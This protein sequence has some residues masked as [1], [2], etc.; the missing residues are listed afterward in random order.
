MDSGSDGTD[1]NQEGE[2]YDS[3]RFTSI[4]GP[5]SSCRSPGPFI[6]AQ[7]NFLQESILFLIQWNQRKH[8]EQEQ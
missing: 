1:S 3:G 7:D 8:Y 2:A 6:L 4:K 5:G